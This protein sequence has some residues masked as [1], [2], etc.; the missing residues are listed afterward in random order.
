MP[1]KLKLINPLFD[2]YE[3]EVIAPSK[4][5]FIWNPWHGCF[6]ISEGCQNCY[7]YRID[8]RHG[9][10]AGQITKLKT[11]NLPLQKDR[12]GNYKIPPGSEVFTCFSSDFFVD[13][14]DAWRPAAWEIIKKRGDVSFFFITKRVHRA[15]QNLPPDWG[16]GYDNVC[17][18]CTTESQ[19]QADFRLPFFKA[20]PIKEKVII[21]EPLLTAVDLSKYL[22]K[23]IS[24]VVAGGES[25]PNARVCNYDWA[26]SLARQC[27]A[28]GVSFKFKQTGANFLK[29]GKLYKI[30]RA[31]QH[32]QARKAKLDI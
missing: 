20:L 16:L 19:K 18:G 31:L 14:A 21:C 27:K 23:T 32:K 25:G 12:K 17:I 8:G 30:P 6:K 26:L 10:D 1:L 4:T 28:A 3:D 29:D 7:V 2:G 11:F 24:A 13:A 5:S 15:A 22:D 9:K